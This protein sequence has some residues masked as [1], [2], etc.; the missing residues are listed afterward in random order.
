MT[1]QAGGGR[2]VGDNQNFWGGCSRKM[3][4]K[5]GGRGLVSQSWPDP[6]GCQ[7][8]NLGLEGAVEYTL[9]L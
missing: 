8:F 4:G 9:F 5:M 2:L 6:W 1:I 3:G 7:A